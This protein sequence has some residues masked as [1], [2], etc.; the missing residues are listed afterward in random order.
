MLISFAEELKPLVLEEPLL[1]QR[2]QERL[3]EE[4]RCPKAAAEP[5]PGQHYRV[6]GLLLVLQQDL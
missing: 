3:P 6:A 1:V 5:A 4:Q 2:L